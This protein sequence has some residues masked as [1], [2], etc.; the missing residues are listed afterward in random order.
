MITIFSFPTGLTNSI[1]T[2]TVVSA[3]TVLTSGSGSDGGKGLSRSDTIAV[4]MGILAILATFTAGYIGKHVIDRV[5][6]A[7]HGS[8][9]HH[10]LALL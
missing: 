5:I 9:F 7:I 10:F 2:K 4:V 6:H 8:D 3:T 1:V